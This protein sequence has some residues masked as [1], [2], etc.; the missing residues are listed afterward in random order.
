MKE[1]LRDMSNARQSGLLLMNIKD[2]LR[3]WR[4]NYNITEILPTESS[5]ENTNQGTQYECDFVPEEGGIEGNPPSFSE[6]EG[7]LTER[8]VSQEEIEQIK[9]DYN[10]FV[11]A[12]QEAFLEEIV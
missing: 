11:D 1:Y 8:G 10:G 9:A 12:N 6:Y 2:G 5:E 7:M 4:L 3:H